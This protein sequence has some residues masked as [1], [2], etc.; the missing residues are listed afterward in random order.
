MVNEIT[1]DQYQELLDAYEEMSGWD[2][3]DG[4]MGH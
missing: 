3:H 4:I 2:R 1:K